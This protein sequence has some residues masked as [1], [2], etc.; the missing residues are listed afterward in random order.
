LVLVAASD[1]AT[2]LFSSS[3]LPNISLIWFSVCAEALS[4]VRRESVLEVLMARSISCLATGNWCYGTTLFDWCNQSKHAPLLLSVQKQDSSNE[5]YDNDSSNENKLDL[6]Q[7]QQ[8]GIY[9][10][11]DYNNRKSENKTGRL[12]IQTQL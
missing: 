8:I 5:R 3:F 9:I 6:Q 10:Y 11:G 1:G 7:Q 4:K 12:M 2:N